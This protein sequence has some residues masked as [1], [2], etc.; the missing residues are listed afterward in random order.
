MGTEEIIIKLINGETVVVASDQQRIEV[1]KKIKR[2][3]K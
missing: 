1:K 3:K 2:N